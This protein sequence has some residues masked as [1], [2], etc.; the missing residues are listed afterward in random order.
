MRS[1][2]RGVGFQMN[3]FTRPLL[4]ELERAGARIDYL[5]I[6]CDT[7]S[8]SLEGPHLVEPRQA[9]WLDDLQRRYPLV[10]HSNFGE[11]FGF[12]ELTET[13][14]VRR[15][16]PIAKRMGAAWMT[17]HMFYGTPSTSYLWSTPIQF[18]VAEIE[19]V[20]ARARALQEL[21]GMPLLHENAF[22]YA[23]FPGSDLGEAEFLSGLVEAAGTYL[24]LDVHN[25]Y[26]NSLNFAGLDA[27]AYLDRLPLDRVL[28]LHVAGG[29]WIEGWYHDL[30]NDRVPEP[31]WELVQEVLE[32]SSSVRGV[33]LEVQGPVHTAQSRPMDASWRDMALR[34]LERISALW[35]HAR[36]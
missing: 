23:L 7:V 11:E 26:A 27:R 14:C 16:I 33:T 5:E 22:I 34:D 1:H 18:S 2:A 19:R 24:L 17:D 21:L 20:A 4:E 12:A 8:G 9:A 10:A 29:Q 25:L 36:G 15:H 28:E 13:P 6:L 31:V 35:S 3:F 30:H 32:R